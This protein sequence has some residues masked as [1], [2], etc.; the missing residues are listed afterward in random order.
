[1]GTHTQLT[2]GYTSTKRTR[3][4]RNNNKNYQVKAKI[5]VKQQYSTTLL[6]LGKA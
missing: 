5:V 1:M 3:T 6:A 2:W 4:I